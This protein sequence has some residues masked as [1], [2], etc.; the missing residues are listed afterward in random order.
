V[1]CEATLLQSTIRCV[2][3]ESLHSSSVAIW[4]WSSTR[5]LRLCWF[6]SESTGWTF[7]FTLYRFWGSGRVL[8]CTPGTTCQRLH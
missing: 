3:I 8:P 1:D 4:L 5:Q 7:Y 2:G 6:W